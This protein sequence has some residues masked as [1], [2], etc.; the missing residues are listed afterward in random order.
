MITEATLSESTNIILAAET[1][2]S[3]IYKGGSSRIICCEY[4]VRDN[5]TLSN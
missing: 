2:Y 4:L 1:A 3:S 5:S